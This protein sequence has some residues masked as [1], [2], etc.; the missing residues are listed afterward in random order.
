M[1]YRHEKC[2]VLGLNGSLIL[3]SNKF[4]NKENINLNQYNVRVKGS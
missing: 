1:Q 2:S 3:I 4:F